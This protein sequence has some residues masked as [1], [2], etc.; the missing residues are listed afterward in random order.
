MDYVLARSGLYWFDA[1]LK[2]HQLDG[3]LR[4]R[5]EPFIGRLRAR[6]AL[7]ATSPEELWQYSP[8]APPAQSR[9]S[10]SSDEPKQVPQHEQGAP[11]NTTN[12]EHKDNLLL[13]SPQPA[14]QRVDWPEMEVVLKTWGGTWGISLIPPTEPCPGNVSWCRCCG[15]ELHGAKC[16]KQ[17][18]DDQCTGWD[19]AFIESLTQEEEEDPPIQKSKLNSR[20]CG[21]CGSW[22]VDR[23]SAYYHMRACKV[24]RD[25]R[26]TQKSQDQGH[27]DGSEH[28]KRSNCTPTCST[29]T[30]DKPT[31]SERWGRFRNATSKE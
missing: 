31:D 16:T 27:G 17:C 26:V 5:E 9:S 14:Q 7:L 8:P 28:T 30:N 20:H 21:I 11:A 23:E 1:Q 22:F 10:S 18:G 24:R 25:N 15:K 19:L 3:S 12:R 13:P 29:A 6:L 2:Q 4:T